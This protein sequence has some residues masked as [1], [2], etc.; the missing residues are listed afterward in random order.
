MRKSINILL[1][2]KYINVEFNSE[3]EN[4]NIVMK[5]EIINPYQMKCISLK[6]VNTKDYEI[7]ST[8]I[9]T[10]NIHTLIK[11]ALKAIYSFKKIDTKE[12]NKNTKGFLNENLNYKNIVKDIRNRNIKD[13]NTFLSLYS[14]IYQHESRNYGDNVSNRLST[15]LDYSEGYVKNITKEAFNKNYISKNNKGVAGGLLS[16]KTLKKLNSL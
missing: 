11:K 5:F 3:L 9:R 15:L 4:H 6:I 2:G 16:T 8:D 13:R 14:Y 10:I 12:F 7:S 1:N